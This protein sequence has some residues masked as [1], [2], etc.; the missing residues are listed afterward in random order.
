MWRRAFVLLLITLASAGCALI[1]PRKL[2]MDRRNYLEAVS[3]SWKEQLL[4]NLI[5]LRY[6]DTLTTLE[7]TSINTTYALDSNVTANYPIAWNPL[8][9]TYPQGS[10][11]DGFR[12]IVTLGGMAIYQDHPSISYSPIRG[13]AL[14]KTMIEP[15]NPAKVLK[16]LQTGWLADYIFPCCIKA[17][18]DL[19]NRSS[20]GN[21]KE[22]PKFF[23]LVELFQYLK[24][25]GVIRI[26]IKEEVESKVTKVPE[27]FEITL[28]NIVSGEGPARK[29][30]NQP[31]KGKETGEAAPKKDNGTKDSVVVGGTNDSAKGD[32]TKNRAIGQLILDNDRAD[33]MD[34]N[35]S[36]YLTKEDLEGKEKVRDK[37]KRFKQLLWSSSPPLEKL[38]CGTEVYEIIDGNQNPPQA[39]DYN[40][41]VLQTRS[42]Y[43][44]LNMLS[45]FIDIPPENLPANEHRASPSKLVGK[46]LNG[47]VPN[48]KM[49]IIHYDENRPSD[50]FVRVKHGDLWF[51]IKD[52]DYDSKDIFTSTQVFLSMFETG[53]TQGVPVL[54]LPVQ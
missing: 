42:I 45:M 49:F 16:S 23:D 13:D 21:I 41:I 22:D 2:P 40:K 47:P 37:I 38:I 51:Y 34:T 14:A 46:P 29:A 36:E 6:G 43:E 19:R 32:G 39:L 7:M 35:P 9:S 52:T 44:T 48:P 24:K 15:I 53:T 8:H 11:V 33:K 18:N 12:N 26:A 30:G 28:H 17:I 1:P 4:T 3:T 10:W 50:A 54:T 25:Y 5:K 31:Q 20:S 27:K